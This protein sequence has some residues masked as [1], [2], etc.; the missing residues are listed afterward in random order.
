MP[1]ED[2]PE[3]YQ[4]YALLRR[5]PNLV[6]H[7]SGVHG[8]EGY[9]G[10]A[11]QEEILRELKPESEGPSLLFLHALNPGGMAFYRRNNP[12]NVDLN[13]NFRKGPA[14][15]NPDYAAFA[16]YMAPKSRLGFFTG[17]LQAA[18]AYQRMGRA[19]A[20]QAIASGQVTF[21]D[22]MFYMGQTVQREIALLQQ[23]LVAHAKDAAK[24]A[25]LDVHTGLGDF[26]QESL[27]V[28]DEL[29]DGSF[30]QS[31]FQRSVT[32]SDPKDG[33]YQNQ[34]RLSDSIRAALPQSTLQYVLQ[35]F[36][37]YPPRHTLN[38][39]RE[40]NFEWHRRPAGVERPEKIRRQMMEAFC[41]ESQEWRANFVAVGKKRFQQ[42][43]DAEW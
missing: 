8:I 28:D 22:G 16:N 17:F 19:R 36:G 6:L 21:P 35:E 20:V 5:G 23:V 31:T 11:L 26:L 39:V 12:F 34:G 1:T 29:D 32:K 9:A 3:L 15:P 41:P 40:E 24:I 43:L 4:D 30:V 14:K 18:W 7:I 13:R 2:S 33:I 38:A 25:V 37:T 10:S 27:F 42:L